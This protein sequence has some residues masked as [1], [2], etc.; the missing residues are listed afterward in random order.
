M[1]VMPDAVLTDLDPEQRLVAEALSGPVMVLAGAG[2]GKTRAITHRIAHAVLTGRH[3]ARTG[4]AVTFT[5]RAAG[6]MR[7]RLVG[8]GVPSVAVRTFHAAALS[9]LRHFWPQAVGGEFPELVASKTRL[10]DRACR[11]LGVRAAG[12]TLRDL[13]SEIEWAGSCLILP[14]DYPRVAEQVGRGGVGTASDGLDPP[15]V[16]RVMAAY[17]EVKSRAHVLD[18]EDVLLAT[19]AMLG[20]RPDILDQVHDVYRWFTVDEFQDITP[21]QEKLLTLWVGERDDV[22]VVGDPSQTIYSFAGADPAAFER[23]ADVWPHTTQI[24][25]D[26]CYRC[27]PQIVAVANALNRAGAARARGGAVQPGEVRRSGVDLAPVVLRAQRGAGPTPDVVTCADDQ[28]EAQTVAQRISALAGEGMSLRDMAVLLR[29][30]AASEKVEVALGQA[31]V[32]YS[33]RGAERFFERREVR[34]AIVRLRGRLASGDDIAIASDPEGTAG[35]PGSAKGVA[36]STGAG[37]ARAHGPVAR[38][39]V[40]VLSGMGWDPEGAPTGGATRERWESLSA[41]VALAEEVESAGEASLGGLVAELERRAA[42]AHAPTVDGVTVA[43]LHAA[44]GLEW[45]VVFIVGCSEGSLPIVHADT[46]ERVEEERRLF[47]VGVT[48]ARDRLVVTWALTR[49]GSGRHREPSRFLAEM[50]RSSAALSQSAT[51]SGLIRQG[52]SNAPR[53]R[54][55]RPPSRCRVCGAGLLTAPERTLGRCR[56]CPGSPDEQLTEQ[57]RAWRLATA[58]QRE[59]PA[60]VVFTDLTLSAVAERKPRDTTALLDIPGIGPAKVELYG[61]ALLELV[62]QAEPG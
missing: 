2:T 61:E 4:M 48:R 43:T 25:L 23:F 54:R 41:L 59:V 50:R 33:M 13:A 32:A 51:S 30:N 21:A 52:R 27:T 26:R 55:R 42:L 31:G 38:E 24:R 28:D 17:A 47:Y 62:A 9:Q 8:L 7:H 19:I 46:A 15:G 39:V 34:E 57:L 3:K 22:C 44:K 5:N 14:G 10:V 49:T 29:T 58:K 20:D 37:G 12:P 53:E 36:P 40:A 45:P 35:A 56:T 6:E 18:F 60:Y 1:A 11:E 16:A